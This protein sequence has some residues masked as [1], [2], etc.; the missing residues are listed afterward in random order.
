MLICF[1]VFAVGQKLIY[2]LF[3]K[4]HYYKQRQLKLAKNQANAKQH[5]EAKLLLFENYFHSSST[6]SPKKILGHTLKNKQKDS[7][8]L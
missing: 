7:L 3:Y 8:Y 6:S 1:T 2:K 4:E 5:P